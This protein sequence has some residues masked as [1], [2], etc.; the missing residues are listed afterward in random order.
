[1]SLKDKEVF[2]QTSAWIRANQSLRDT[3]E[4]AEKGRLLL[5][6]KERINKPEQAPETKQELI[7][8]L[9]NN[10]DLRDT[11]EY[12]EK[13]R[14]LLAIKDSPDVTA[15]GALAR[16]AL[17]GATFEFAD[18]IIAGA[19]AAAS[20]LTDNPSGQTFGQ[21]Y[22]TYKAEEDELLS[23]YKEEQGASYLGGQVAGSVA[24]LPLGG[25]FGKTGQLLFGVGGR[26]ATA[27][28]TAARTAAAG[29]TQAGLAGFG[30]GEDLESRLKQAALGGTIGGVFAGS[31]GAAGYKLAEKVA[32]SSNNIIARAADVGAAPRDTVE[33]G[34]ELIPQL[35]TIAQKAKAARDA[36][37]TGWRNKLNARVDSFNEAVAKKGAAGVGQKIFKD[38]TE[39][40]AAQ[41]IPTKSLKSMVDGMQGLVDNQKNINAIL[42]EGDRVSIDT[43]R[44][45]YKA[46]W[47][48]QKQLAPNKAA[49]LAKKL[50]D[51][52]GFEY[53]HLDSVFPGIGK[54]R[55]E[56]DESVRNYET[57]QL[58]N[59]QLVS[60]VARGEALEPSFA[61][62]FLPGN[63]KNFDEFIALKSRINSWAKEAKLSPRETDEILAPLRANALSDVV[64]N[65]QLLQ[66][67]LNR[68]TTEDKTLVR[69]YKEILTP[70]QFTFV[71][72][73]AK[74]PRN[75]LTQRLG[76][77]LDY[78]AGSS[79][80][81]ALGVGGATA[82]AGN[83]AGL[84]VIAAYV[85]SPV[86]IRPIANN[87][88]LLA[89]AT[90]IVTAPVDTPPKKLMGMTETL[91]KSAIKAGVI[92]PTAAIRTITQF[93]E[94]K[95]ATGE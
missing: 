51:I 63:S 17:Q 19:S 41:V 80:L 56:L 88:R 5:S 85:A 16:G 15:G 79:A 9:Q 84:A 37:Y 72:Q 18:E 4:Y 28:Q 31:L 53:R 10:Q 20:Y 27:A 57:G 44:N 92:T 91:G 70:E 89:Q 68:A 2:E 55:K 69:H 23:A 90:R 11:P 40:G 54:A 6:I 35:T 33:L 25:V 65:P 47:D 7:N 59:D 62:K 93:E 32:N 13:G 81:G 74:M 66:R 76:S 39:E 14:A 43:Y 46:A 67:V 64:N 36:A 61:R 83:A 60:K 26:G 12:A 38:E 22:D 87:P 21:L 77:L 8:W 34:Q 71:N 82:L 50:E 3:P 1:M 73:L 42:A 94:A 48:L 49:P 86:L 95:E 24:T 58:L 29:A 52:K 75:H 45:M 78:Y 30:A